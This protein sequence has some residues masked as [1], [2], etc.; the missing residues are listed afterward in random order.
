MLPRPTWVPASEARQDEIKEVLSAQDYHTECPRCLQKTLYATDGESSCA[1]CGYRANGEEAAAEWF[2]R[3]Y[4]HIYDPK[5]RMML[6]DEIRSCPE[7]GAWAA[8]PTDA[9]DSSGILCL[10]CG[11]FSQLRE[12]LICGNSTYQEYCDYHVY[13]MKKDD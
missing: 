9:N 10:S 6:D 12:C 1:F 5:E 11:L 8:I 4:G 3:Q 13:T 2:D 7:C